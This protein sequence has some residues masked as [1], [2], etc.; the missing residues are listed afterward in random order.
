[1]RGF[2]KTLSSIAF[3]HI[4][5][6]LLSL[7]FIHPLDFFQPLMDQ[8]WWWY[9]YCILFSLLFWLEWSLFLESWINNQTL[10]EWEYM[11]HRYRYQNIAWSHLSILCLLNHKFFFSFY[12]CIFF[13]LTLEQDTDHWFHNCLMPTRI[14]FGIIDLG[15]FHF[16]INLATV[17]RDK[18]AF[19]SIS[20]YRFD[21]CR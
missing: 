15:S 14:D 8:F 11:Q 1:M 4:S 9:T 16:V 7:R 21:R 10:L 19:T 5:I 18:S 6:R 3:S 2:F 17:Q 12:L 13:F 20:S